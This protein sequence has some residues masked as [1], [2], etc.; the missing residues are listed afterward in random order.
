MSKIHDTL[1]RTLDEEEQT[2]QDLSD[3]AQDI[4]DEAIE[5]QNEMEEKDSETSTSKSK[6][7]KGYGA[8]F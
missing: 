1:G 2:D 8:S 6:G 4:N 3:L 5:S 7:K